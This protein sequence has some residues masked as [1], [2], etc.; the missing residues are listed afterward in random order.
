MWAGVIGF[1]VVIVMVP[2]TQ[3]VMMSL[4]SMSN[5]ESGAWLPRRI[6]WSNYV[7][8]FHT[9]RITAFI[10]HSVLVAVSSVVVTVL[11]ATGMAYVLNRFKFRLRSTFAVALLVTQMVPA[12]TLL[13]PIYVFYANA[14]TVSGLHI[15]G[16]FPGLIAAQVAISLPLT[17]WLIIPAFDSVSPEIDEAAMVDGANNLTILIR[18]VAPLAAPGMVAAGIFSFLASWN[19]VIFASVLTN[20]ATRTLA[21]G[22]QEYVNGGSGGSGLTLWNQ[23]MAAAV[24]STILPVVFF[25]FAQRFLTR[26]L[27]LGAVK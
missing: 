5:I 24:I 26:G 17:I 9:I 20:H 12:V 4:E 23:L 19:D 1:F 22:L 15:I 25:F 3:M 18:V 16:S 6:Y 11:V 2:V 14:Q 21:I 27:T 8:V 10:M 13:L 7:A